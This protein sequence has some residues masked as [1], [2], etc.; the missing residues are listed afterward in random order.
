MGKWNK[1]EEWNNKSDCSRNILQF[2]DFFS[3]LLRFSECLLHWF[4][5]T[6]LNRTLIKKGSKQFEYRSNA[7]RWIVIRIASS[8]WNLVN[9][10]VFFFAR[11]CMFVVTIIYLPWF[12]FDVCVCVCAMHKWVRIMSAFR[13]KKD[14]LSYIIVLA[15]HCF[16]RIRHTF[17]LTLSPSPSLCHSYWTHIKQMTKIKCS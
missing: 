12:D 14:D 7:A 11:F 2:H 16:S 5:S 8:I 3:T 4:H 6:H 10:F 15:S 1:I 9:I 13:S 17:T